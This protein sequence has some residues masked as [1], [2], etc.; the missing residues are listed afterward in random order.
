MAPNAAAN[1]FGSFFR[2]YTK[3]W[4]HAVATAGLTAFGTL[5]IVHRGFVVLALASYL[6]PPIVL[7]LSRRRDADSA[8]AATGDSRSPTEAA[9]AD[10]SD[11]AG[12]PR[13]TNDERRNDGAKND[14]RRN[15]GAK[16]DGARHERV[17]RA[18]ENDALSDSGSQVIQTDELD[19]E[20]GGHDSD[21]ETGDDREWTTVDTPTDAMLTDVAVT[22]S[23]GVAVGIGGVVLTAPDDW[24]LTLEDGPGAQGQDLRAVDATADGSVA[25]VVGDGGTVGRL[26]IET[27]RQTDHSAPD[28]RTD[29]LTG[30]AVAGRIGEETI[31][32]TNGSGEVIRGQY[33]DGGLTWE[34]PVTPGSGSSLSG[35]TLVDI[36]LGYCCDTNAGVFET[37]DGGET[38]ETIGIDGTDG[39]LTDVV[40]AGQGDCYASTDAGIV[41]RYDGRT[42]TPDRV[43]ETALSALASD[44]GRLVA[45]DDDGT[46]YD[47][48]GPTTDWERVVTD[49]RG[50]LTGV[51]IGPDR[52]IAVG[53]EGTVIERR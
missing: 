25:W 46:I 20:T 50:A 49:T 28:D 36:D 27:G 42:W 7:Y 21:D 5:T 51:A 30:V 8:T 24:E 40:A 23:G 15:D 31:F 16:N 9:L 10:R 3:T 39:T 1:G 52:S 12:D 33:S 6:V 48:T 18:A 22:D 4:M 17:D 2:Q 26:A 35:V 41:H 45:T 37:T 53:V 13:A 43:S 34:P 29:N 32:L 11:A 47:R 14:G 44:D 38:F 19:D